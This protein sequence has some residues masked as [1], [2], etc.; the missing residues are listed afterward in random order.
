MTRGRLYVGRALD[1]RGGAIRGAI[2]AVAGCGLLVA[3]L[4]LL[5][6]VLPLLI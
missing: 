3:A 1:E 2:E 5:F 4:G 6:V